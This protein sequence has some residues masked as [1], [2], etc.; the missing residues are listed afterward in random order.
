MDGSDCHCGGILSF[1]LDSVIELTILL[2][3]NSRASSNEGA[4]TNQKRSS[5]CSRLNDLEPFFICQ[6]RRSFIFASSLGGPA[7]NAFPDY[8]IFGSRGVLGL[9]LC[10]LH[11]LVFLELR[12]TAELIETRPPLGSH[13]PSSQNCWERIGAILSM[14]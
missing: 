6:F 14:E 1:L 8:Y 10:D 12:F 5:S 4:C 3:S 11:G 7:M 13:T 2:C 9:I